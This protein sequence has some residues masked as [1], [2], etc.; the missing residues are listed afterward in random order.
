LLDTFPIVR[1]EGEIICKVPQDFLANGLRNLDRSAGVEGVDS[2]GLWKTLAA[3][4]H[5]SAASELCLPVDKGNG[6][7]PLVLMRDESFPTGAGTIHFRRQGG[8]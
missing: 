6:D 5:P 4:L 7:L 1:Q 8:S 2:E 3:V